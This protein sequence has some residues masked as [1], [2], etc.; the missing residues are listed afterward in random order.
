MAASCGHIEVC[1]ALLSKGA[2]VNAVNKVSGRWS[3]VCCGVRYYAHS[4]KRTCAAHEPNLLTRTHI[5][6]VEYYT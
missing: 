5:V 6:L 4:D 1:V 3:N 2:N